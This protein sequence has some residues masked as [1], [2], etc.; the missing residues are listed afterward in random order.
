MAAYSHL[1]HPLHPSV[2]GR[3][4]LLCM[5]SCWAQSLGTAWGVGGEL[6]SNWHCVC[7]ELCIIPCIYLCK[8]EKKIEL[9]R[10]P[11]SLCRWVRTGGCRATGTNVGWRVLPGAQSLRYHVCGGHCPDP[12]ALHVRWAMPGAKPQSHRYCGEGTSAW[13]QNPVPQAGGRGAG[14]AWGQHPKP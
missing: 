1:H 7:V 12:W 11:A 10:L 13:S 3:L 5:C 14:S 6:S 4:Q 2:A 9:I 8:K